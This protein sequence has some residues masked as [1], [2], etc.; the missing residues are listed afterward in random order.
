MGVNTFELWIEIKHEL[1]PTGNFPGHKPEDNWTINM[2]VHDMKIFNEMY[3]IEGI[4]RHQHEDEDGPYYSQTI[5]FNKKLMEDMCIRL[6]GTTKNYIKVKQ[7]DAWELNSALHH[8]DFKFGVHPISM[9]PTFMREIFS[10]T[11]YEISEKIDEVLKYK[12][13]FGW[14]KD[15]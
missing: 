6:L 9:G 1:H 13:L 5:P 11:Q 8:S 3:F 12:S 14:L 7:R 2:F 4:T 15:E 10:G